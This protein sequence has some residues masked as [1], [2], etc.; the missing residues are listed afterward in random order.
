[1]YKKTISACYLGSFIMAVA[2]NLS[3]LLYVTFMAEFGITFEQVG[4][5]TLLNFFTQ[6]ITSLSFSKPTDRHGARPFV[7][8]AHFMV[9]L[10]FL[11][12]A[13]S[14]QLFSFN[15][16]VGLMVATVIYSVGAGLFELLLN[17]IILNIPGDAKESATSL[18][19]SFYAW[20]LIVTVVI[21]TILIKVLGR[22]NWP[23]I[24]LIWSILPL[25]NFFNFMR[26]PFA[27][28]VSEEK[29]TRLTQLVSS[30]YFILVILGIAVGGATEVSMSQWTSTFAESTLGLSKEVGDLVGLCLFALLLGTAR[31]IFG[32]WKGKF[33]LLGAMTAGALLCV[34][35]YLV[36]A[37]SPSPMVSLAAC[38]L[39]GLGSGLLW[40]GSVVNAANHFPLAGAS[41]FALLA[42]GGNVGA[43]V[44][45]WLI[46]VTADL[47]P[48]LVRVAPWLG[49]L[50]ASEMALR[51]GMLVGT[52][53]PSLM[54][55]FL[56][57]M[58]RANG[59]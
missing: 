6:I 21:T 4:R 54:V 51:S 44:G 8:L 46:G 52:L 33:P 49:H 57:R 47:A 17:I 31:A 15:P 35:C 48:T 2:C 12:L 41:L 10:G 56:W 28:Q 55:F 58:K 19:H 39:C 53:F 59:R 1:M 25:F 30:R 43:A 13:F 29:R 16:Y 14:R 27:P 37:L 26:V 40:P 18:L 34:V 5:L 50:T 20:G 23:A 3:P 32:A 45:P 7:T 24:I 36:A 22:A 11:L 38:V 9:F 42:A